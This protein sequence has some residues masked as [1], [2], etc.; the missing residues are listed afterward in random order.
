[1][2]ESISPTE[3]TNL[4]NFAPP[5]TGEGIKTNEIFAEARQMP[6]D[7]HPKMKEIL[8]VPGTIV[9]KEK[10][11]KTNPVIQ[12]KSEEKEVK[13]EQKEQVEEK[14]QMEEDPLTLIAKNFPDAPNAEQTKAWKAQYGE[15][16]AIGLSDIEVFIWRPIRYQEYKMLKNSLLDAKQKSPELDVDSLFDEKLCEK[17]ILWP[18]I[19]PEWGT[20]TKAGNIPVLAEMIRES[21]NFINPAAAVRLVRKL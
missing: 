16:F 14:E 6:T 18:R 17:C 20:L 9:P 7:L 5:A 3:K 8:G 13:V 12:N 1:M 2:R 15:V 4:L 19:V 21:S 11:S 10:I